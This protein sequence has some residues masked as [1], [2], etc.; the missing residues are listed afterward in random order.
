MNLV[1]TGQLANRLAVFVD[2]TSS[3][4]VVGP[5]ALRGESPPHKG[6]HLRPTAQSRGKRKTCARLTQ[7]R[8]VTVAE[9]LGGVW[10]SAWRLRAG[11][12]G[13]SVFDTGGGACYRRGV[14][15]SLFCSP[16]LTSALD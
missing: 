13:G 12:A 3:R 11:W 2:T 6:G 9:S 1:L 10:G 15:A 8:E 14:V 4:H 7:G 16:D 5:L